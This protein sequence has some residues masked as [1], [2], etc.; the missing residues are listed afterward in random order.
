VK[1]YKNLKDF[2]GQKALAPF[3][4]F[5]KPVGAK[6]KSRLVESIGIW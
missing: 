3:Q 2:T 4:G 5:A 6:L 1:G